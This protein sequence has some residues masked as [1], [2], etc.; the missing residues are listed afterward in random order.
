M[1]GPLLKR[2]SKSDLEWR[3]SRIAV[4]GRIGIYGW[5]GRPCAAT[6]AYWHARYLDWLPIGRPPAVQKPPVLNMRSAFPQARAWF[7]VKGASWNGKTLPRKHRIQGGYSPRCQ[8][9]S[10]WHF[11]RPEGFQWCWLLFCFFSYD[12]LLMGNIWNKKF[13][14]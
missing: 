4:P 8:S 13:N 1:T 11:H 14:L 2:C 5:P 9:E 10:R 7:Q 6:E 12:S 3:R